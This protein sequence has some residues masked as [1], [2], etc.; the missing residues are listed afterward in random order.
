MILVKFSSHDNVYTSIFYEP[1]LKVA[2]DVALSNSIKGWLLDCYRWGGRD[3]T[4]R[5]ENGCRR[6]CGYPNEK[7]N[8]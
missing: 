6:V 5:G 7:H 4:R 3:P 8:L 1:I 2:P